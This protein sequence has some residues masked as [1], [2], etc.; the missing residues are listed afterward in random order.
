[1]AG[2][3]DLRQDQP[4]KGGKKIA[5]D[6]RSAVLG[7]RQFAS[8]SPV[9]TVRNPPKSAQNAGFNEINHLQPS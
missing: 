2:M 8:H 7:E 3:N 1:M 6:K 5:P 9:G 4:W